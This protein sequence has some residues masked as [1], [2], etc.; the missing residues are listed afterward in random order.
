M[1]RRR[2]LPCLLLPVL[3]VSCQQA[4]RGVSGNDWKAAL[5]LEAELQPAALEKL[6]AAIKAGAFPNTH[7]V[8]IEHDGRL[9]YE[10][11]F[12]G[13]DERWG[14]PIGHRTFDAKALHDIRSISKSVTAAVLGIALGNEF[15]KALSR[16]IGTFSPQLKV[17]PELDAV[18]LHHVLTPRTTNFNCLR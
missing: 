15:E 10:P 12:A 16:P 5:P 11:Y 8:L 4:D 18:T 1:F 3:G 2:D 6:T 7:A 14:T 17:P 9:V 13:S